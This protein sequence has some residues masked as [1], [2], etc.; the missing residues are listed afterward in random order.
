MCVCVSEAEN[1]SEYLFYLFTHL[2]QLNLS[3]EVVFYTV[4]LSHD[5]IYFVINVLMKSFALVSFD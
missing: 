2:W 3:L 4:I 1:V 5:N